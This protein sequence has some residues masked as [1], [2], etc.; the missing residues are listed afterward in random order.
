MA[1]CSEVT[2]GQLVCNRGPGSVESA[3][4]GMCRQQFLESRTSLSEFRP[5]TAEIAER[6]L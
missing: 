4:V 1:G 5:K 3:D 2:S 6:S